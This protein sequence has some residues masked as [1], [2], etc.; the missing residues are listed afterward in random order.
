MGGVDGYPRQRR[1]H[2]N[3]RV[4][5]RPGA[6]RAHAPHQ[7][8]Y[9]GTRRRR[10]EISARDNRS[11]VSRRFLISVLLPKLATRRLGGKTTSAIPLKL[12]SRRKKSKEEPI[13]GGTNFVSPERFF[14]RRM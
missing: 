9:Q 13:Y 1:N 4:R 12:G 7:S 14:Y 3:Y 2:R 10:S 6:G 11:A 8:R 5:R